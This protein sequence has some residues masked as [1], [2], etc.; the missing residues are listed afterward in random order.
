LP[1]ITLAAMR[2][3]DPV[4]RAGTTNSA[5]SRVDHLAAN[6][7]AG[8]P[9]G[10]DEARLANG[11]L[12]QPELYWPQPA[13]VNR[14]SSRPC[15][16]AFARFAMPRSS[17]RS[18]RVAHRHRMFEGNV[19]GRRLLIRG[20]FETTGR[21]TP[22]PRFASKPLPR[23]NRC[24]RAGKV[25]RLQLA[26]PLRSDQSADLLS[27][28]DGQKPASGTSWFGQASWGSVDNFACSGSR[29]HIPNRS[30][31]WRG[32]VFPRRVVGQRLIRSLC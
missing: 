3:I 11:L 14:W 8:S 1:D 2:S 19:A 27:S 13:K 29:P 22:S 6:N 32:P 9:Q 21:K 25:G 16:P 31:I 20:N 5:R 7:V 28:R 4:A 18:G 30:T 23:A 17:I 10:L 26:R 12:E 15:A 24:R